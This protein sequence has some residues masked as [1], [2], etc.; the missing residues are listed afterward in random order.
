MKRSKIQGFIIFVLLIVL[1]IGCGVFF[2]R[3][4]DQKEEIRLRTLYYLKTGQILDVVEKDFQEGDRVE[5]DNTTVAEI[6]DTGGIKA[7]NPGKANIT[8]TKNQDVSPSTSYPPVQ[9]EILG[10]GDLPAPFEGDDAPQDD[11]ENGDSFSFE[12]IVK[13]PVQGLGLNVEIAT[14]VEGETL[15]LEPIFTPANA[16]NKTVSYAS[17]QEN[18]A[19]VNQSGLVLAK[20]AGVATIQA[21]SQDGGYQSRSQITVL[22]KEKTNEVYIKEEALTLFVGDTHQVSVTVSPEE[23]KRKDVVY[24]SS[25]TN[26]FTVD[27]QGIVMARSLGTANLIVQLGTKSKQIP[28]T[29]VERPV[30][31]V[32]VSPH[33]LEMEVGDTK[34]LTVVLTPENA[35]NKSLLYTV[36]NENIASVTDG[37]VL[38]KQVGTTQI[39]VRSDSGK[40]DTCEVEV[41]EKPVVVSKVVVT[42]TS[43]RLKEGETS[44]LTATVLPTNATNKTITYTSLDERIASVDQQGLITGKTVGKTTIR[45]MSSSLV[46]QDISVEVIQNVVL[47]S[48]LTVSPQSYQGTIGDAFSITSTIL[49]ANTTNQTLTYRSS[50]TSIASVT[51]NGMVSLKKVGNVSIT[52]TTSNGVTQTIPVTVTKIE[53]KISL[54][55]VTL[56]MKLHGKSQLRY[57]ILPADEEKTPV[58]FTSSNASVVKVDKEGN[59]EAVGVGTATIRVSLKEDPTVYAVS[60]ITVTKV[61]VTGIQIRNEETDT[62]LKRHLFATKGKTTQLKAVVSPKN[63]SFDKV[64]WKSSNAKIATVDQTGKVKG[65][66][67]GTATITATADGKMMSLEVSVEQAGDKI[68]LMSITAKEKAVYSNDAIIFQSNG[69]FGLL[70]TSY[71]SADSCQSYMALLNDLGIKQIDFI[72]ISHLHGDHTGCLSRVLKKYKV[73][74]LYWK[75]YDGLDN[76]PS[77]DVRESKKK[78]VATWRGYMKENGTREILVKK[79]TRF[80]MEN[81]AFTPYNT[82]SAFKKYAKQCNQGV[83]CNENVNT[84]TY[85]VESHGK[86][87]YFAGDIQNAVGLSYYPA[88]TIAKQVGAV[89]FLKV[90]HHGYNSSNNSEAEISYLK[91]KYAVVTNEVA[92]YHSGKLKP[93]VDRIKKYTG[94]RFYYTNNGYVSVTLNSSNQ[95]SFVQGNH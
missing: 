85:L 90:A 31:S 81:F 28:I 80:A 66:G 47:A 9:E 11:E 12:V 63:A 49:P 55:K 68:Y 52:V 89:D 78:K 13:E 67:I 69:H 91:P 94:N 58:E 70:D 57:H 1:A 30:E 14:L 4:L 83:N 17:F 59:L 93:A 82:E 71:S 77:F 46:Y 7:K 36:E 62:T 61:T 43:I 5:S 73:S 33:Y 3:Y 6:T 38:A 56:Q 64:T 44:K 35:T 8:V 60:K 2:K 41:K 65:V 92:L 42:P 21:T 22:E 34:P 53:K 87:L 40:V 75:D 74:K 10:E 24:Q 79:S 76:N 19:S 45:V 32:Q 20:S 54:D 27:N 50:D 48:S 39:R 51:T 95:F 25:N 29:V 15:Q 23:D 37:K 18:V 84:V 26:V 72:A 16:F 88:N 86:K